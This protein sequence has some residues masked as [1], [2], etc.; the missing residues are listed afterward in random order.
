MKQSVFSRRTDFAAVFVLKHLLY[1]FAAA[2]LAGCAAVSPNSLATHNSRNWEKQII[3]IEARA[4]TNAPPPGCILFVGS[5]SIR[6]WKTLATDF[7]R[8]PVVNHGFGGSQLADSVHF[9]DRIIAPFR[10]R[11]VV[12]YAGGND[13][14][15]GK[16]ARIVYGD[17]VALVRKIRDATPKAKIAFISIAPN[18]ARWKEI[19]TVKQVNALAERYCRK[20][21]LDFINVFPLML[22]PDGLPKP[23][24]YVG[25]QLH[26]NAKGYAIWR[27]AVAPHLK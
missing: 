8:L 12:I 3:E 23:D 10:P 4:A 7:P 21:G 11:L 5:S 1:L 6:L 22:G 24:I 16:T 18:P 27:E 20:H 17:F 19:E 2:I 13:I 25:D 26:M 14:N 9:T 15:A